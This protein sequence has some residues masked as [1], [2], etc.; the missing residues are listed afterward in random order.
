MDI[1][2]TDTTHTYIYVFITYYIG[3]HVA[4]YI[5]MD[6]HTYVHT[7]I[8]TAVWKSKPADQ[9]SML[10]LLHIFGDFHQYSA[11][12]LAFFL[13]NHCN[14]WSLFAYIAVSWVKVAIFP[15]IRGENILKIIKLVPKKVVLTFVNARSVSLRYSYVHTYVCS[16]RKFWF[17]ESLIFHMLF[18]ELS[19]QGLPF[20]YTCMYLVVYC[21]LVNC[22]DRHWTKP[23]L[24]MLS[25]CAFNFLI[26]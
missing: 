9:W 23:A 10:W 17:I 15:T 20:P 8:H 24:K 12:K 11:I 13:E 16:Y 2:E 4:V 18:T 25:L 26:K 19:N 22:S 5:H 6:T 14:T 7:Y 21:T 3:L 1:K